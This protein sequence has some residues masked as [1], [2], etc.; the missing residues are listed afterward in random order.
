MPCCTNAKPWPD[1]DFDCSAPP[2]AD[3]L[4]A[5]RQQNVKLHPAKMPLLSDIIFGPVSHP[6]NTPNNR[7]LLIPP[8]YI[9]SLL[10]TT[11]QNTQS[12][13]LIRDAQINMHIH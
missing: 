8:S 1:I 13:A 2:T 11:V 7:D 3:A 6:A 12:G 9:L 5:N 10:T 4:G